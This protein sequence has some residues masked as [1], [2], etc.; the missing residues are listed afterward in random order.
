MSCDFAKLTCL[1]DANLLVLLAM[2]LGAQL[3][4]SH[5]QYVTRPHALSKAAQPSDCSPSVAAAVSLHKILLSCVANA[6]GVDTKLP[7]CRSWVV[8][9]DLQFAGRRDPSTGGHAPSA[10]HNGPTCSRNMVRLPLSAVH[11]S[12]ASF[13]FLG[14]ADLRRVSTVRAAL[15]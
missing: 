5:K 3:S 10:P 14:D 9:P 2:R 12:D 6:S 1:R 4:N 11:R 13:K 8:P 7:R 15:A